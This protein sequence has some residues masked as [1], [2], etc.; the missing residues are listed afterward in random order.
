MFEPLAG[1]ALHAPRWINSLTTKQLLGSS[2]V[3]R[4]RGGVRKREERGNAFADS[5]NMKIQC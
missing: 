2:P 4:E 5:A 3:Q 1:E